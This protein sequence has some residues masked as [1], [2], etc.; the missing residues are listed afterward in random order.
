M[1]KKLA[2]AQ[3]KIEPRFYG[4]K[5]AVE[6][7]KQAAF[8]KYDESVDLAIRL[9]IDPKRSDQM[10]RGTTALPH[11]TGKKLRVLVFAKGEKEQEARQAGADYVGSDD[12]MEKIKGGWMDFDCAISTPDL[13]ASVGK[14]GKVLGPRGL[15]PNPKTGTVTFEVGKAVGDIRKGRVEFKVEKAGIVQVPVGKVSFDIDKLYDTA[16]AIIESVIKAKPASCKGRYLKTASISSTMG[17]GVQLD[18]VALTKQ[19]S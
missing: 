6:V 11:G 19:W 14:L 1:G 17:P 8:A 9:G 16:A 13:M 4:L 12:L 5:E 2:A 7:V 18:T 15:M 10:V 3:E